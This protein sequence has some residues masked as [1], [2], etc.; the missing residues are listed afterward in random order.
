MDLR[1]WAIGAA[2][3]LCLAVGA[4]AAWLL[5]VD[6]VARR[7]RP[8]AHID[9]LTRLPE[10]ARVQRIYVISMSITAGLLLIAFA[11]AVAAAARPIGL[12]AANDG[13]DAAHPRD[14]MLCVGQPVTDPTT[15]DF[16]NYYAAQAKSFTN[17]QIGITSAVCGPCR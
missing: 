6:R 12:A 5:P 16:L 15:A 3:L 9:R 1:W 2:G 11:A 4:A 8:L 17:E 14:I 10:F 7:L 13:F